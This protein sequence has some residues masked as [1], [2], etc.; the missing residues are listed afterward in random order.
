M[1]YKYDTVNHLYLNVL[2]LYIKRMN[3]LKWILE[4]SSTSHFITLRL[5]EWVIHNSISIILLLSPSI[6]IHHS[7]CWGAREIMSF[8][9]FKWATI[10]KHLI[11][12]NPNFLN[13]AFSTSFALY[14]LISL[15]TLFFVLDIH[16]TVI[17]L[18]SFE[19]ESISHVSF[20]LGGFNF[21][22]NCISPF[23]LCNFFNVH[24]FITCRKTIPPVPHKDLQ[25][26]LDEK[27]YFLLS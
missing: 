12:I 20:F 9:V 19:W 16:F 1:L 18:C 26:S 14:L 13:T 5:Q 23:I 17:V 3:N 7:L 2:I 27:D 8:M 11:T 25:A 10:K 4:E 24:R 15:L 6:L 22:V 21:F